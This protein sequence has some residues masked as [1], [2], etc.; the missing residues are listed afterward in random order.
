MSKN[1]ESSSSLSK[2]SRKFA[3]FFGKSSQTDE[4]SSPKRSRG[5]D[6]GG[7]AAAGYERMDEDGDDASPAVSQRR[8]VG[9][10]SVPKPSPVIVIAESD[11]DGDGRGPAG[12]APGSGVGAGDHDQKKNSPR[13]GQAGAGQGV[14]QVAVGVVP[15]NLPDFRF[16]ATKYA[17]TY[18][19]PGNL[20]A[21]KQALADAIQRKFHCKALMVSR[22]IAPST[23]AVHYHCFLHL[24]EKPDSRSPKFFDFLGVHPNIKTATKPSGWIAYIT[25]SDKEPVKIGGCAD[26]V[27][28]LDVPFMQRHKAAQCL[29]ATKIAQE[30]ASLL[31]VKWPVVFQTTG[32]EIRLEKP[33]LDASGKATKRRSLWI[34]GPPSSGKTYALCSTFASQ[35]VFS[36][37]SP[38]YP[39]EGYD[40]QEMILLDD[41][42]PGMPVEHFIRI[43]NI[44]SF[45][46]TVPGD[47]R[48]QSCFLPKNQIRTMIVMTNV[49]IEEYFKNSKKSDVEVVL[50]IKRMKHRFIQRTG[51]V[52]V[53]AEDEAEE[54]DR[55]P[56]QFHP[57]AAAAADGF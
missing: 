40:G 35:S 32:G 1:V 23:G 46:M 53:G 48:Y 55:L 41:P 21:S 8:S 51:V 54:D 5:G 22:E 10:L 57:A 39:F 11:D 56:V 44:F 49:T 33:V 28:V 29:T 6:R 3:D 7:A 27:S 25:K 4:A 42:A 37:R 13:A 26:V 50:D 17:L 45:Q 24:W 9:A 34:V 30:A 12:G 52:F 31:P 36:V 16:T 19:D 20:I 47:T 38:K 18:V 2:Q 43:L 15:G 14:P